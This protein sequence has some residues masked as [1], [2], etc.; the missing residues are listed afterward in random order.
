MAS[1]AHVVEGHE[2]IS[3]VVCFLLSGSQHEL[4]YPLRRSSPPWLIYICLEKSLSN[5]HFQS[6]GLTPHQSRAPMVVGDENEVPTTTV[7]DV[8]AKHAPRRGRVSFV[9]TWYSP[10]ELCSFVPIQECRESH[11]IS[12]FA[13]LTTLIF[14]DASAL[15]QHILV[16]Y[17]LRSAVTRFTN[18][19]Q[20][21][22]TL[23]CD[24]P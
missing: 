13:K 21:C 6:P 1:L 2:T 7:C 3:S 24:V 5:H 16:V 9:H 20:T 23:P 15:V 22:T 18:E 8:H 4:V 19:M 10:T 12:C 17:D 11:C 14:N